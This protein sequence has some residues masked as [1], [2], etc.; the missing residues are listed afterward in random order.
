MRSGVGRCC[1]AS[2]GSAAPSRQSNIRARFVPAS[3]T[4]P[5]IAGTINVYARV[6]IAITESTVGGGGNRQTNEAF[7]LRLSGNGADFSWRIWD[8]AQ[9]DEAFQVYS[10]TA[11]NP[12]F[13]L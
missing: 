12:E 1:S 8:D 5:P 3:E 6:T 13:E 11:G 9:D 10:V 2:P 7:P 4:D